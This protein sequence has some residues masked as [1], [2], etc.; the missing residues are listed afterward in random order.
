MA[1]RDCLAPLLQS[2]VIQKVH[3]NLFILD[4]EDFDLK[5]HHNSL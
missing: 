2:E 1:V 4:F 5:E 3:E